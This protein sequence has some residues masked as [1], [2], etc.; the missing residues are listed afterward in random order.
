MATAIP[1]DFNHEPP[2]APP[3]GGGWQGGPVTRAR[4]RRFALGYALV[5]VAGLALV[6]WGTPAWQ[7]F[8]MG[9]WFPGAGFAAAGGWWLLLLPVTIVLFGLAFFAWFGSG[10]I[11]APVGVWAG[12]AALAA[13]LTAT[14]TGDAVWAPSP[15]IAA[16]LALAFIADNRRRTAKRHAAELALRRTR[17]E[18]R[19]AAEAAY[20]RRALAAP[21]EAIGELTPDQLA[22]C[23]YGLDRALQPVDDWGGYDQRDIFQTASVRYQINFLGYALAQQQALYTPSF[24]GYL[25]EAQRRLIEKY[26]IP[27]VWNYWCYETS[28]GHLNLTDWNP[29][30]KDNV[31]LTGYLLCQTALY[32][33]TTGD[34]RYGRPGSLTFRLNDRLQWAHDNHSVNRSILDNFERSSYCLYPCEPNWIYPACNLRGI[35]GVAAYDLA[36]GTRHAAEWTAPFLA[37][38]EQEFENAAGSVIALKSSLLGMPLPFPAS[39]DVYPGYLNTFAPARAQWRW[40]INA[41]E[42]MD[43]MVLVDGVP[44][45]D[46]PDDGIDFGN[47]RKGGLVMNSASLLA[48]AREMGDEDIAQAVL[49]TLEHRGGVSRED[50]VLRY[51]KGSN[52]ANVSLMSG[53]IARRNALQDL[54]NRRQDP[55]VLYGPILAEARYPDVLVARAVSDGDGLDL[56]LYGTPDNSAHRLGL[57]RLR[58]QAAYTIAERPDLR[59]TADGNGEARID[60]DLSGRTAL[61]IRRE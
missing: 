28:W 3:R 56:V 35:L 5:C 13:T 36:Y 33:A 17:A 61:T 54:Y 37:N 47:Y 27:R 19:P 51:L 58:P 22:A 34:D 45:L 39:D 53:H 52:L 31:M 57:A 11:V 24:H 21:A 16:G 7:A 23:R 60:I 8:G 4:L 50:G 15:Y 48:S 1:L 46:I 44:M 12:A 26:L 10:M 32:A 43:R 2:I 6:L 25:S 41:A 14:V 29:A 9:L 40:A 18:R 20:A 38:L 49:N 59:F 42:L 55:G 30:A